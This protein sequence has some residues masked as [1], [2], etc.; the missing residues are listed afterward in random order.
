[1][2]SAT[3]KRP[4]GTAKR[5]RIERESPS[6]PSSKRPP[7]AIANLNRLPPGTT[8]FTDPTVAPF[9]PNMEAE[10]DDDDLSELE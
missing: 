10:E 7:L 6:A 9:G 2:N 1:M 8:P 3:P 5:K 4:G